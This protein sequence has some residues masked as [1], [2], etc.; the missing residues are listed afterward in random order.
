MKN[1]LKGFSL[2][3]ILFL[4]VNMPTLPAF[5]NYQGTGGKQTTTKYEIQ[6]K[7]IQA[8]EQIFT[9]CQTSVPLARLAI[10]PIMLIASSYLY[11]DLC[12]VVNLNR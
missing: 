6:A 10:L 9:A 2:A 12:C 5:R 3:F 8:Y 1:C 7:S 11:T 4:L